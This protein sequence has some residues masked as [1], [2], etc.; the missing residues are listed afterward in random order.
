M[1]SFFSKFSFVL[2]LILLLVVFNQ[3]QK[4]NDLEV[5]VG[6][7]Y[8]KDLRLVMNETKN[9]EISSD[10]ISE[11]RDLYRISTSFAYYSFNLNRFSDKNI[12]LIAEKL[13][14]IAKTLEKSELSEGEIMELNEEIY[15]VNQ[16]LTYI[17]SQL[18]DNSKNWYKEVYN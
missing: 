16:F 8:K 10:L 18:P 14:Y 12:S 17:N 4:I 5:S 3:F 1:K 6:S 2:V 15:K 13:N 9:L 7:S 11:P